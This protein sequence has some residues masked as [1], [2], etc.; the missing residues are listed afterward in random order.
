M[1]VKSVYDCVSS[2]F[3]TTSLTIAMILFI[4][5]ILVKKIEI[6]INKSGISVE[7]G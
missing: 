6:T 7:M 2:L 4:A 5:F 1:K 3:V